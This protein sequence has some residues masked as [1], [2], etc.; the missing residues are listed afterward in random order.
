[1][2][3]TG[4]TKWLDKSFMTVNVFAEELGTVTGYTRARLSGKLEDQRRCIFTCFVNNEIYI[5][6][7][8]TIVFLSRKWPFD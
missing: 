3:Q 7:Y 8:L 4:I 5:W 6:K 2:L 1:M